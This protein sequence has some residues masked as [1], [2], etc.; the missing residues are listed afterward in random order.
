[1]IF[2]LHGTD[3]W[4]WNSIE[5]TLV[6]KEAHNFYYLSDDQVFFMDTEEI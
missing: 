3:L 5:M 4:G 1:M 2:L 6:S